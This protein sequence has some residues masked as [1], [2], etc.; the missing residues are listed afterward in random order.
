MPAF[1]R[2]ELWDKLQCQSGSKL[3]V[4]YPDDLRDARS[5]QAIEDQEDLPRRLAQQL[6][7]ERDE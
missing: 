1:V 7:Q 2:L 3:A 5:V 4:L 6:P